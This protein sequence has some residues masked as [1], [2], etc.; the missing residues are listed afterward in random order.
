MLVDVL[1]ENGMSVNMLF[2]DG[3]LVDMLLGD[4]MDVDVLVD[5]GLVLV[6]DGFLE[7][8]FGMGVRFAV[9]LGDVVGVGVRFLD[10]R[11][12]DIFVSFGDRMLMDVFLGDWVLVDV[13]LGD[14]MHLQVF[15]DDRMLVDVFVDCGAVDVRFDYFF[16]GGLMD[17]GLPIDQ[18][19]V[20]ADILLG[21][22][23]CCVFVSLS[24]GMLMDV[25]FFDR[26]FVDMLFD[27]GMLVEMLLGDGMHV[28]VFVDDCLVLMDAGVFH[29]G[30]MTMMFGSCCGTA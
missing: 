19:A 12:T 13:L 22:G 5:N 7:L 24:D 1:L 16:L 21:D 14:W 6:L 20:N 10:L 23:S 8:G 11:H 28:H 3:M 15:L 17:F 4:G 9:D 26:M 25:L 18:R 27:D 2:F 30:V 29:C